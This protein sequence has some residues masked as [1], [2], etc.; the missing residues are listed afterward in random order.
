MYDKSGIEWEQGMCSSRERQS[1]IN[2]DT[3]LQDPPS[4]ILTYHY[5]PIRNSMLYLQAKEGLIFADLSTVKAGEVVFNNERYP[6][7]RIDFHVGSEHLIQGKR[8]SM[9]IQLVHRKMENPNRNLIISILVSTHSTGTPPDPPPGPALP[10]DKREPLPK[11]IPPPF[12]DMGF[13][14]AIQSFL[15]RR[16]PAMEGEIVQVPIPWNIPLDLSSLI[17][18]PYIMDSN[19]YILYPGSHTTPPCSDLVNWFVK[20][21]PVIA[22]DAQVQ[23]FAESVYR[24]T[25][26]HGNFRAVMPVNNR[27]LVVYRAQWTAWDQLG[28]WRPVPLGPNPRTDNEYIASEMADMAKEKAKDSMDYMKDFSKR[29]KK[30]VNGLHNAI[31]KPVDVDWAKIFGTNAQKERAK[32]WDRDVLRTQV[33]IGSIVDGVKSAVD[34]AVREETMKT[35]KKAAVEGAKAR[36]M[37]LNFKDPNA[38]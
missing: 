19:T 28:P 34:R 6:L 2:F 7:T 16:P 5:E 13:N 29:L 27:K 4:D 35:H 18:N 20:R 1:P 8:M 11:Y 21:R 25:N 36:R 12:Y 22:S 23:A 15:S 10:L 24:L 17:Q 26:K 33:A 14:P 38:P 30:S 9:E 32:K 37:T 3:H 31:T